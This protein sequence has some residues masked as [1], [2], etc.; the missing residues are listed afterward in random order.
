VHCA[1]CIR[2]AQHPVSAPSSPA[3][4]IWTSPSTGTPSGGA[5]VA[6]FQDP[7]GNVLSL[8]EFRKA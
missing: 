7:D 6:W 1:R 2:P 8:T 3:R 4:G 5:R